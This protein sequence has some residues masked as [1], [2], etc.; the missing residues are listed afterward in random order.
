M[1]CV[2]RGTS[3]FRRNLREEGKKM[4]YESQVPTNSLKE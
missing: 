4:A 2:I 1:G 3:Y